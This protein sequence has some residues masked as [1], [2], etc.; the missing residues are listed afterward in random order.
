M[1]DLIC[2]NNLIFWFTSI[3]VQINQMK[4]DPFYFRR[5][6][7]DYPKI[8]ITACLF[9]NN[10]SSLNFQQKQL[11]LQSHLKF[12][13]DMHV[14][15]VVLDI[16]ETVVASWFSQ[17]SHNFSVQIY[18]YQ[19]PLVPRWLLVDICFTNVWQPKSVQTLCL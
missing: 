16:Y 6:S 11:Y 12:N 17:N 5:I 9:N 2:M 19:L 18:N 4:W 8:G 15:L 13:L 1:P 7:T 3:K 10:H 14:I